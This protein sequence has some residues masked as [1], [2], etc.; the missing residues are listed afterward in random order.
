MGFPRDFSRDGMG[1]GTHAK[2]MGHFLR[3]ILRKTHTFLTL[4]NK[5]IILY[6]I[7]VTCFG[8]ERGGLRCD[9]LN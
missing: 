7:G 9:G 5:N 8:M 2:G 3:E 6:R 1:P 4:V